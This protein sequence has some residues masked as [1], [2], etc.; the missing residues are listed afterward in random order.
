MVSIFDW[1]FKTWRAQRFFES[2][3]QQTWKL[4]FTLLHVCIS[5]CLVVCLLL[6][7][8][9]RVS[10][11]VSRSVFRDAPCTGTAMILQKCFAS[12]LAS[13][14]AST[15]TSN[16]KFWRVLC[17]PLCRR[18]IWCDIQEYPGIEKWDSLRRA[19]KYSWACV[20]R[21]VPLSLLISDLCLICLSLSLSLSLALS[22][23]LYRC[24]LC[25][26]LFHRDVPN[27]LCP[28][29]WPSAA[30][31]PAQ[32]FSCSG[33]LDP[34]RQELDLEETTNIT[35]ERKPKDFGS[36]SQDPRKL[37]PVPQGMLEIV[38]K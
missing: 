26:R 21:R 22:L 7:L 19:Q 3:R 29:S 1:T 35:P 23:F 18:G 13:N 11:N 31:S 24:S 15:C 6:F 30:R 8:W 2:R 12:D 16:P 4:T 20:G 27:D 37:P 14:G 5:V 10:A 33:G 25:V 17:A 28:L 9:Q 32:P 36:P 38:V 34:P